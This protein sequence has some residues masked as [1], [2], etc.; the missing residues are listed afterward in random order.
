MEIQLKLEVE[1][2]NVIVYPRVEQHRNKRRTP[3]TV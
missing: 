3:E 2:E 1:G